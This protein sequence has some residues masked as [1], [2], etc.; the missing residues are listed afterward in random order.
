MIDFTAS[1]GGA[2][3]VASLITVG[4]YAVDKLGYWLVGL[5]HA[6]ATRYWDLLCGA[7]AGAFIAF[8]LKASV[9]GN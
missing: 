1:M 5:P 7:G 4:F 3:T 9:F 8:F 6:G 2:I